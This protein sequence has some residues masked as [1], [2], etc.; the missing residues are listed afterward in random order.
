VH[1]ANIKKKLHIMSATDLVR[2]AVRWAG[3]EGAK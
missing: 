1:R 2:Y 3:L